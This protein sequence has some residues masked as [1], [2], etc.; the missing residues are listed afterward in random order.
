M[1]PL[2]ASR[3]ADRSYP[4][5]RI[6]GN[7]LARFEAVDHDQ[8]LAAGGAG[9]EA[10]RAARDAELIGQQAEQ[11]LVRRAADCWSRDTRAQDAVHD[12]IDAVRPGP[13][14]QS[15]GEADVGVSQNAGARPE[16]RSAR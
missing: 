4:Q 13:R 10:D 8:L 15:D 7:E 9:D 11:R 14:S 3:T 5:A 12:P 2:R 1:A 6:P 16:G